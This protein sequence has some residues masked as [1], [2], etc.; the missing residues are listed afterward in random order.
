MPTLSARLAR[1]E[2]RQPPERTEPPLS[3]LDLAVRAGLVLDPWQ[4]EAVT[5]WADRQLFNVTRQ[6]G[7]STVAALRAVATVL[8]EP[9]ALVLLVSRALRQSQELF[10]KCTDILDAAQWPVP[11]AAE[12]ALRVELAGG[13]RII[14]L[15]GSE[16]TVRGYSQVRLLVLDEAARVP[17][18]VYFSLRPMLAVSSGA[19]LALSTPFGRRGWWWEA[20]RGAE[21]WERYEVPATDCARIPATFLAEEQRTLGEWW[22]RQEYCCEFMDAQTQAFTRADID[23]AFEEAVVAWAL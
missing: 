4:R 13:G 17:D 3:A 18:P 23:R 5:S 20:W 15:P 14:S 21:A 8:A 12:S 19:V 16:E 10:R 9:G 2:A 6:G 22:Y 1:V 7:K 11:A